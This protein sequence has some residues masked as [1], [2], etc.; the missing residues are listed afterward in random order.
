MSATA[1]IEI[2]INRLAK[3]FLDRVLMSF[4]GRWVCFD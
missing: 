4:A 2:T 1:K 3:R